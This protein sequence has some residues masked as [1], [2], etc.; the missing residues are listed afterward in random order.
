MRLLTPERVRLH[1]KMIADSKLRYV[2]GIFFGEHFD[3]VMKEAVQQGVA[4]N[5]NHTWYFTDSL[6]STTYQSRTHE[7]GSPLIRATTGTGFFNVES[8]FAPA[9]DKF[10]TSMRELKRS[11]DDLEYIGSTFPTYD[12]GWS[13]PMESFKEDMRALDFSDPMLYD[14]VVAYGLA[15]CDATK[16]EVYFT[17]T[18]LYEQMMQTSFEGATGTVQLDP[19]TGTRIPETAIFAITN[20]VKNDELNGN[21]MVTFSSDVTDVFQ[22]GSWTNIKPYI[23]ND[24]T[25]E[26]PESLPVIE[27]DN[28][29]VELGL[30]AFCLSTGTIVMIVSACFAGWTQV[31]RERR[32][33]RASQPIFLHLITAGTMLMGASLTLLTVDD[34]RISEHGCDIACIVFPWLFVNGFGIAF[35]ALLTKTR[36]I[37]KILTAP[38]F[39]RVKVTPLDVIEIMVV[40]LL[41]K[42]S[43]LRRGTEA[44]FFL[45]FHNTKTKNL[46]P[47]SILKTP[48]ANTLILSLWTTIGEIG[49]Q[50]EIIST[51]VFGRTLETFGSC[52][53][54][55]GLPYISAIIVV[56]LG[57]I[58]FA[59]YEAYR[60]RNIS[61]EF[62]E[63]EYV[64]KALA[65]M[66]LVCFIGLPVKIVAENQFA[67]LF[68]EV[69]IIFVICM[70]LLG[71][72]F[73]PK[74]KF[75][76]KLQ[77]KKRTTLDQYD[78][79][80]KE[81]GM[82][83][84]DRTNTMKNLLIAQKSI[85]RDVGEKK[86]EKVGKSL[87]E[88]ERERETSVFFDI[89][90]S[91]MMYFSDDND[92][93][94][95]DDDDDDA[96]VSN[97]APT[98][99][100]NDKIAKLESCAEVTSISNGEKS[101]QSVEETD[102]DA[103][104][105]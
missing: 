103:N 38:K 51:D 50:R 105:S 69:A 25:S 9:F 70:S 98:T 20:V 88:L 44:H 75:H 95:D 85:Q 53:Y 10:H 87:T 45:S 55:G 15:A 73:V 77:K 30:R 43:F 104:K 39:T 4:G 11:D 40:I 64:M 90:P 102:I 80:E 96:E 97:V 89:P 81:Y 47:M 84:V 27:V 56:N 62:A 37:N 6:K 12:D 78:A 54:E 2:V 93:D 52:S 65:S 32:V 61:T 13:Y 83:I 14:T 71:L 48:T 31:N 21:G 33:V 66:V 92:D 57:A 16:P 72:I 94:N 79:S 1:V 7:K 24:G 76:R 67:D 28:N 60:A 68:T 29:Y 100:N 18:D 46:T 22:N 23:Y 49:W 8:S 86:A 99:I 101:D 19:K 17:G 41:C 5:G 58:I 59:I 91:E 42:Y 3:V 34:H 26:T 74:I 63:S 35:A 82:N 36:R